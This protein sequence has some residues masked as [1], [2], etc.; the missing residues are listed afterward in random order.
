MSNRRFWGADIGGTTTVVGSVGRDSPF[1][2]EAVLPTL[3]LRGARRLLDELAGTILN[4]DPEP[5]AVGVG[6]AGLVDRRRGILSFS[7]NLPDW[8]PLDVASEIAGRTGA[9][10]VVDNDC[11]SF[12]YGAVRTGL[13]PSDG[14][15][16]FVT[17]GTGIGGT[18]LDRGKVIYGTGFAGEFG[19]MAVESSGQACPCGSTGCWER[20]AGRDALVRYYLGR[21]P[22]AGEETVPDPRE[23]AELARNGDSAALKAF[24]VYGAWVGRGL[25]SLANCLSPDGFYLAG[26]LANASDL[27]MQPACAEFTG[28]CRHPWRVSTVPDS[29]E[30]GALGAALMA[31]DS[32]T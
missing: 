26:G 24:E 1:R 21:E 17:L 18:I 9:G 30:A 8:A 5:L 20:Y 32:R 7:P 14:L 2:I 12:A 6:I 25:A 15:R 3:P 23:I 27:F 16:I 4:A 11:N 31:R 10:A 29:S 28:R 13:I 19:H 22:S